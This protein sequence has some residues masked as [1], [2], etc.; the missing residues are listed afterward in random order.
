MLGQVDAQM[1]TCLVVN[2]EDQDP[3][4]FQQTPHQVQV[5]RRAGS[6]AVHTVILHVARAHKQ[7]VAHKEDGLTE[8]EWIIPLR[9]LLELYKSLGGVLHILL[10]REGKARVYRAGLELGSGVQGV[11]QSRG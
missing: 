1:I 9:A 8:R 11:S 3:S 7:P 10:Q 2:W 6:S 5:L 4:D